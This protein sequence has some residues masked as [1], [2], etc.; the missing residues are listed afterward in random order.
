M[1]APGEAQVRGADA[2][3]HVLDGVVLLLP[4]AY[5]CHGSSLERQGSVART[6]PSIVSTLSTRHL[7]DMTGERHSANIVSAIA[8]TGSRPQQRNTKI[9]APWVGTWSLSV[10]IAQTSNGVKHLKQAGYLSH[11][12]P[13]APKPLFS[14]PMCGQRTRKNVTSMPGRLAVDFLFRSDLWH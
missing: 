9:K 4:A 11:L 7:Q 10:S 5:T 6:L 3:L 2:R 1:V 12:K 8:T 14:R 13:H